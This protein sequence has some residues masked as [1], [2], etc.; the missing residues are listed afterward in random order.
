[1][2]TLDEVN[3]RVTVAIADVTVRLARGG[4]CVFKAT[5][6]AQYEEFRT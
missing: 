3:A 5:D 4:L 2:N 6:G 1:V